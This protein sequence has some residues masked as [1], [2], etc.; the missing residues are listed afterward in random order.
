VRAR[1]ELRGDTENC[2]DELALRDRIAFGDP[3]K[4]IR[5]EHLPD[6]HVFTN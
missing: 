1:L 2:V 3:G 5:T 4:Y 6:L